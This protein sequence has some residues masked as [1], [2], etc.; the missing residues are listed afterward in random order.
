MATHSS[1]H[2]KR[3]P[4]IKCG[5]GQ[6]VVVYTMNPPQAIYHANIRKLRSGVYLVKYKASKIERLACFLG[7]FDI[8]F[9][10]K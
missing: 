8:I 10:V 7:A 1:P 9:Q 2:F 3:M 6:G 5:V 4:A